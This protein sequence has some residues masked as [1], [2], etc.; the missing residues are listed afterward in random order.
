MTTRPFPPATPHGQL[1]EVFP[2]I[3]LVPGSVNMMGGMRFCRNMVVLRHDGELTLVHSMRLDDEG[4]KA[5]DALGDVKHV[6][7][8]A[9]FHGMDD[10]FYKARYGAKVWAMKKN[11]YASG[12]DNSKGEAAETYFEPDAYMDADTELPFPNARIVPLGCIVGEGLLLLE[13]DGGVVIAGDSLQNIQ[14]GAYMNLIAKIAMKLLGFIK[15]HSVG[16]GW[17]K[18]GKA[19]RDDVR[20]IL[21]LEF[22]HVLP[23][24]GSPVKGGARE[25]FRPAIEK[26]T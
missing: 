16:G 23:V 21:D 1:E 10:P 13:R 22:E 9:G 24:H 6:L 11:V 19:D 4:L 3:F 8:I 17:L 20:A 18:Q 26:V 5:L 25:K 12:F 7:R 2:D 14:S 15:P